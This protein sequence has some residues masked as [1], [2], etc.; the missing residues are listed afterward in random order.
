MSRRDSIAD[1]ATLVAAPDANPLK[2]PDSIPGPKHGAKDALQSLPMQELQAKLGSS[3]DGLSQAE[4]TKRLAQYGPN[5]IEEKK[6]N[7]FL[8][9]LG[10]FW[11]PIPWM[12][13][14]AV[15]MSRPPDTG[16]TLVSSFFYWWPTPSSVSGKNTKQ[17]TR[18]RP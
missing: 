11:G 12:I 10:Y 8:K 18:S 14:V 4:A 17:A 16:R 6:T 2:A 1:T 7:E 3:S 15:I 5:E 13:E 9:F